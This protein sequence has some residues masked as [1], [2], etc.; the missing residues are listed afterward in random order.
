MTSRDTVAPSDNLV[1]IKPSTHFIFLFGKMADSCSPSGCNQNVRFGLNPKSIAT[2][3]S[4]LALLYLLGPA[5]VGRALSYYL[6][7]KTAGR[8]AQILELMESEEK[9]YA[10]K[11][12]GKRDSDEWHHVET[13]PSGATKG[14]EPA[15]RDWDGIVGFFHP[16]W[17]VLGLLPFGNCIL[18][19]LANFYS[20]ML[21]VGVS[22]SFGRP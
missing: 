7:Q 20:V 2:M 19:F 3:L 11:G 15:D 14:A 10:T 6:K 1:R 8:R 4:I 22:E 21:V 18:Q 13:D 9:E 17:C 5:L 12:K 16:F